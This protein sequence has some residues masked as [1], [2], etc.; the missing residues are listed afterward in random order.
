VSVVRVGLITALLT[1]T[2]VAGCGGGGGGSDVTNVKQSLTRELAA[3]AD[4]DGATAC[5]LATAAGQARLEQAVSG[6]SCERVVKLLAERLP[7][8]VKAGLRS[9]QIN[10]VTVNGDT[11]TVQDADIT[12]TRGSLSGF[13]QPGSAPTVLKKQPDGTWKISG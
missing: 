12:S 9:A 7:A 6:A 3:L 8:Q 10:K 1:G 13:L 2:L 11:A 5:S 4:G